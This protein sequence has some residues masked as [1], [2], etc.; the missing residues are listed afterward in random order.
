MKGLIEKLA[1]KIGEGFQTSPM[2]HQDQAINA[3]HRTV[4]KHQTSD[5]SF[6][7]G[8]I[9]TGLRGSA[10]LDCD[11]LNQNADQ[12]NTAARRNL[13][14]VVVTSRQLFDTSINKTSNHYYPID[15][16]QHT[17]AFQFIANSVQEAMHLILIAHRIAELSLVPGIVILNDPL[18]EDEYQIPK[19][20][21]I[22]TY[23]GTPDDQIECPT[24]S[25]EMIF[26]KNR[27][28]IPNW[29][30][31][32]APV[33]LGSVK[34][35]KAKAFEE[36]AKQKYFYDHLPQLI[37]RASQEYNDLTG[38]NFLPVKSLGRSSEF[39]IITK[40]TE[41]TSLFNKHSSLFNTIE[42]IQINQLSPFPSSVLTKHLKGKKSITILEK[43]SS[44][45]SAFYLQVLKSQ[46]EGKC[47]TYKATYHSAVDANGIEKVINHMT[48]NQPQSDYYFDIPFIAQ[49]SDFPKHQ[50]LLQEI[51]KHYPDVSQS[52]VLIAKEKRA[53]NSPILDEIPNS[54]RQYKDLGPLYSHLSRFYD[55]T[56]FFH[57]HQLENE[58]VAD[59]MAAIPVLPG[60]SSGFF[61]HAEQREL[62]PI[63]NPQN[64]TGCGDCFI[65]CPHAALPPIAIGVEELLRAGSKLVSGKGMAVTRLTPMIKNLAKAAAGIILEINASSPGDFLPPAFEQLSKQMKLEGEKFEASQNELQL[66]LKE[67]NHFPIAITETFFKIPNTIEKGSGELFSLAVSPTA[68]TGCSICAEVCTEEAIVMESQ[69]SDNLEQVRNQYKLWEQLPDTPGHTINKLHQDENYS[70]LAA[71]L[72]SRNYYMT[73]SGGSDSKKPPSYKS[74][75]HLITA[76]AES[77]VQP[78][79][80]AQIKHVDQLV[81]SLSENI[82]KKLSAA[83]PKNDLD[84]LSKS[85]HQT[86][87]RKIHLQDV[88]QQ[89]EHDEQGKLLDAE[90][91]VRKTDLVNDLKQLKWVLSEGVTG[92]GRSRYGLLIDGSTSFEWA[93]KYPINYF[94]SPCVI[95]WNGSASEHV[96]GL[97]NGILRFSLDHLKLIR[98][99]ELESTD[100]YDPIVHNHKIAELQWRDLSK[101][102]KKWIPPLFLVADRENLKK[103]GWAAM[104]KLLAEEYPIKVCLFDHNASPELDPAR[105]TSESFAGLISILSL[106]SAFVFQ[107]GLADA[108]YLFKG[109]V[110]GIDRPYPAFFRVYS[111]QHEK[112]DVNDI[113][114]KP[115][116]QLAE[117]SRAFPSMYYDPGEK[118]GFLRGAIHL[119]NNGAFKNNWVEEEVV[120]S[121]GN[122][123]EYTVTWAD[124]AFTQSVWKSQFKPVEEEAT[125]IMIPDYLKLNAA[126][127]NERIPVIMRA[128]ASGEKYYAVTKKVIEMTEI[129]LSH[130]NTLQELAGVLTEFPTRLKEEITQE[131]QAEYEIKVIG[132]KKEY[133]AKLKEME[134]SQAEILRK[135]LKEKLIALSSMA[136]SKK[137][138]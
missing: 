19:D 92:G 23:L 82:H 96:L 63:F 14:L 107:G 106:K 49:A 75:L 11:Q 69:N 2:I 5:L 40:G 120:V 104:Q 128:D 108:Q 72:L 112:H 68:C 29:F 121:P 59:P 53:I 90:D 46:E 102:E 94:T 45:P 133:E 81:D 41:F 95:H 20:K 30:S 15:A 70:S 64:C 12:L 26:G 1:C 67:V 37:E 28:R 50:I 126:S 16:I 6:I 135:K 27:R 73:M 97:Y 119:E 36:A 78:K 138:V 122:T 103:S 3:F 86:N 56:A 66:I 74:M 127:R 123:A 136:Q 125:I 65:H 114:W 17:G 79:I 111:I 80:L 76:T 87:R 115:Y 52:S 93:K 31:F 109:L 54:V 47:K 113:D 13:P 9:S 131:M 98:R 4:S 51:E 58:I 42:L 24:P 62:L 132:I 48:S 8:L 25:Q 7:I 110:E 117:S 39:A 35:Q 101:T 84:Q 60:G 134:A 88:F 116:A 85:L 21:I 129:A 57:K 55:Q 32:E 99:A 71:I 61:D 34:D 118:V 105:D 44:T 100:K 83:L 33:L 38:F 18:S 77:V 124:W 89:F 137:K 10:I 22:Q 91:L 130:W 43:Q